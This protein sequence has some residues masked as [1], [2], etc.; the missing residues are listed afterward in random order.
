MA[1]A[2]GVCVCFHCRPC[3]PATGI[4][5]RAIGGVPPSKHA[6]GSQQTRHLQTGAGLALGNPKATNHHAP[7]QLTAKAIMLVR[8]FDVILM[9]GFAVLMFEVRNKRNV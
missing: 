2:L 5:A 3:H 4:R 9:V 1:C 7:W 8:N 6:K